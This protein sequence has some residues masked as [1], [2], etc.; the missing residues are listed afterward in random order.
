MKTEWILEL[1]DLMTAPLSKIKSAAD[2]AFETF[3]RKEVEARKEAGKLGNSMTLLAGST[4]IHKEHLIT[5]NQ[6][7]TLEQHKLFN[8]WTMTLTNLLCVKDFTIG[9]GNTIKNNASTRQ[10]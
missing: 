2:N 9:H 3:K 1:K 8:K 5:A 7:L 6:F 4:T 10:A